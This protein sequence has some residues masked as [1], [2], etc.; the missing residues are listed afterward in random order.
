VQFPGSRSY[1]SVGEPVNAADLTDTD[2]ADIV[3]VSGSQAACEKAIEE[4]KVINSLRL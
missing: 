1:N 4:L 3:K 2:P